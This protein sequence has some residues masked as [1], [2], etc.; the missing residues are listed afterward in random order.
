MFAGAWQ[1]R[2]RGGM[3]PRQDTHRFSQAR[4]TRLRVEVGCARHPG[5]ELPQMAVD[6]QQRTARPRLQWHG[7]L[8]DAQIRSPFQKSVQSR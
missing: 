6:L 4:S 3:P 1:E 5:F 7:D 8:T 2:L